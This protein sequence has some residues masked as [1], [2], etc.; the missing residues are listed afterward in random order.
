M[1]FLAALELARLQQL[2]LWQ[3]SALEEIW[4]LNRPPEERS[5]L[6][7]TGEDVRVELETGANPPEEMA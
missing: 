7:E 5:L 3:R 2:R 4:I 1:T 6:V